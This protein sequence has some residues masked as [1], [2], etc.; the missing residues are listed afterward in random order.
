M[1]RFAEGLT[2]RESTGLAGVAAG[3]RQSERA[4]RLFGGVEAPREKIGV[5]CHVAGLAR[6]EPGADCNMARV[7]G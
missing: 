1:M 3:Q 4:A 6:P 7:R 5:G 2:F